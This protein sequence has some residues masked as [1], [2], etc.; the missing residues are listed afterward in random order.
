ML[1]ISLALPLVFSTLGIATAWAAPYRAEMFDYSNG[2]L[3]R[4][5]G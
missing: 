1:R 5:V 4:P 3:V 2:P